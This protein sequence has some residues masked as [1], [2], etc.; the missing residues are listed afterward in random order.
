M[1]TQRPLSRSLLIVGGSGVGLA[2]VCFIAAHALGPLSIGS[3]GF[4]G[5][6]G[7]R[8]PMVEGGGPATTRTLDWPGGDTLTLQ[9]PADV[10]YTQGTPARLEVS[11]PSRSVELVEVDDGTIKFSRRVHN[12]GDLVIRLTAPDVERFEVRGASDLKV[13]NYDHE[14]LEISIAGAADISAQGRARDAEVHI[15]GAGEVNLAQLPT[16]TVEVHISGVGET[17]AAPSRRAEVHIAGAGD[18]RLT[19]RPPEVESHIAGPGSI[20]YEDR[21]PAPPEVPAVPAAPP[22]PAVGKTTT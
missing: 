2:L 3:D 6:S 19:T 17:V 10:I 21:P 22:A 20:T 18:V 9:V 7:A 12:V 5:F 14:R 11:G 16:E 15:A 13:R 1:S 4:Q 8:G